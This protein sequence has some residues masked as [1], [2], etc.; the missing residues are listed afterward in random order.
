MI[1]NIAKLIRIK[2]EEPMYCREGWASK[3]SEDRLVK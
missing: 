2:P 1:F 3:R